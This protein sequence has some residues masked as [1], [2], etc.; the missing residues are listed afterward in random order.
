MSGR[1]AP[2]WQKRADLD[3]RPSRR[4][5]LTDTIGHY[6]F[7]A[8]PKQLEALRAALEQARNEI[9]QKPND[10]ED[11]ING[12]RA[13]AERAVR[14]TNVEHWPLVNVTLKDG[15]E[16]QF[17]QFQIDPEELRLL[18]AEAKR[19]EASAR[20]YNV[21]AKVRFALLDRSKSTAEIVTEG[22][23]WAKAQPAHIEPQPAEDNEP[24]D[25]DKEWDR[26]A[27]VMAA[28][29]AARDCEAP[30]RHNVIGWAMPV[31]R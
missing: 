10:G 21:R 15:S 26:R 13:T 18:N 14:M 5:R 6:V 3:A 7:H 30:D 24:E 23:E 31:L 25:F 20:H 22:I 19:V 16:A 1:R 17:R 9:R 12:L 8:E 29:L 28:A 2:C 11:P 4:S 27:V